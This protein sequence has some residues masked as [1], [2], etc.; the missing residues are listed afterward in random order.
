[1][2]NDNYNCATPH[3]IQVESTGLI[4]I[5]CITFKTII[6]LPNIEIPI[7]NFVGGC[8][9][10]HHSKIFSVFLKQNF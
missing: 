8:T 9:V 4:V 1:M 7:S 3:V 10:H 2:F 6:T 5:I